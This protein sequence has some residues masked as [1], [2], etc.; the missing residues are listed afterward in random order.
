MLGGLTSRHEYN[1][2][3]ETGR[4]GGERRLERRAGSMTE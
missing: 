4:D 2:E 3:T 1:R